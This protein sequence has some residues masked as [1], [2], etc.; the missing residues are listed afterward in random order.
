[1]NRL[2]RRDLLRLALWLGLLLAC[3]GGVLALAVRLLLVALEPELAA[4]VL[5]ALDRQA[6]LLLM[7][8]L[9]LAFLLGMLARQLLLAYPVA[10]RHLGSQA[11]LL[12]PQQPNHRLP[13]QDTPEL[14]RLAQI[15]N[16]LADEHQA[17]HAELES[18]VA[19]ASARVEAERSRLAALMGQIADGVI[20]CNLDGQILLYN[21]QARALFG[22]SGGSEVGLGRS[23]FALLDRGQIGH[24]LESLLAASEAAAAAPAKFVT[25]TREGRLLRVLLTA[26]PAPHGVDRGG[27]VLLGYLLTLADV[28]ETL[29]T[30]KRQARQ[31]RQLIER[32]RAGLGAIRAAVETLSQFPEMDEAQRARFIAAIH[33][34]SL[35]LSEAL[36]QASATLPENLTQTTAADV[37][38]GEDLLV[39]LRRGLE[40]TAGV[41]CHIECVE[42]VWVKVDGFGLRLGLAHLARR[43]RERLGVL[44]PTLR[45]GPADGE[46]AE[47]WLALDLCWSGAP[48]PAGLLAEWEHQ[49]IGE[50]GGD[51]LTL[52][53]LV[54]RH[55]GEIWASHDGEQ[56]AGCI[57][58]MLPRAPAPAR[59]SL[60]TGVESR[61]EFYD[62]DLFQRSAP[63]SAL[64]ECRLE[65]ISYTV[66]DTETTGLDPAGGDE[67][68]SIGAVRIV[69]GRLLRFETFE[70]LVDP[71]RSLPEA[72]IRIHG[73]TPEML[74]GQPSIDAVLPQFHRYCE[75]TVLVAHNA[76]F[77]LRFLQLKEAQVGL[78][79]DH[80][81]LDTL[82]L[83]QIL[84]PEEPLHNLEA[85][86]ERYGLQIVGRHT[87][88]GDALVT[89]EALLRMIPLLAERGIR[90]LS[91]AREA[92]ARSYYARIR[93]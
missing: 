59:L 14:Q 91:Q 32:S 8:G 93:Y 1:M 43:L 67:I 58:W 45:I 49:S 27:P 74:A 51:P 34:E 38:R 69:N 22:E 47:S 46:S 89:G 52:A 10:A 6:P 18:R 3:V 31:W 19:A 15:I 92:A 73:I 16:T 12:G 23:V 56:A 57:R 29:Q 39:S 72:S 50:P 68:I 11:R 61:P 64:D 84:H 79:F 54:E 30:G 37:L 55:G 85:L 21:A 81:V 90:T 9:L 80:P 5:A 60:H 13:A 44:A 28:T 86:S 17:L 88:L 62:F 26:V 25:A 4:A 35:R 41:R 42:P 83:S 63:D 78:R 76:A 82:L 40:E 24:A 2:S 20:V 66:F 48:L 77:D 33:E 70:Q 53:K 75:G 87:A 65:E 71:R 36:Q 7:L